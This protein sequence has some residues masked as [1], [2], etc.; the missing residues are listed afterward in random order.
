MSRAEETAAKIQR[1]FDRYP[2]RYSPEHIRGT[3]L[4]SAIDQP[5]E[6]GPVTRDEERRKGWR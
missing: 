6:A 3:D 4:A 1:F 2:D 5:L